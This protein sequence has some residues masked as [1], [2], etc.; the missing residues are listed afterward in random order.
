MDSGALELNYLLFIYENSE[1]YSNTLN[2]Y[3]VYCYVCLSW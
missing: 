3:I 1:P 2:A